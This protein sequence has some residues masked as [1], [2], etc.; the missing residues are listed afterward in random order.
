MELTNGPLGIIGIP[1]PELFGVSLSSPKAYC[2]L[3]LLLV[4]ITLIVIKNIR[5]SV[6]DMRWEQCAATKMHRSSW[7]STYF[8]IRSWRLSFRQ[9]LQALPGHFTHSMLPLSIRPAFIRSVH[10]DF[11]NDYL[12]RHGLAA[13][14][15]HRCSGSD[16]RCPS[17]CA[18]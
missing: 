1:K 12:W 10:A 2:F 4:V 5:N 18:T 8:G 11:D 17:C 15:H 6:L 13:G 3:C 16:H 9:R 7:V 14:Q